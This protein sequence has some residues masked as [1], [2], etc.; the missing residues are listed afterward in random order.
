M[1]NIEELKSLTANAKDIKDRKNQLEFQA[2]I[3]EIAE[4]ARREAEKGESS[5]VIHTF[6]TDRGNVDPV[7][8]MVFNYCQSEGLKPT[9]EK[10]TSI[11]VGEDQPGIDIVI[12]WD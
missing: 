4:K 11:F 8:E 2:I 12:H 10:N 9:K 6:I 3:R 7:S 5:A 1:V